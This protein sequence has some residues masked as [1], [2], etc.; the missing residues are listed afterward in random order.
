MENINTKGEISIFGSGVVLSDENIVTNCHVIK[1]A[2]QLKVRSEGKKYPATLRYSDQVRDICSLSVKGLHIQ[3]AI[4]GS[5]KMLKIGEKVY[6]IGAPS[7]LELTLS[8]GI[9]SSLRDVKGGHY[10]QTTAAI[11]AGS[12]G[13]GMFDENAM[14][15]GLTTFYIEGQNLNFAVPI[16]WVKELA[17]RSIN[18]E[19][20]AMAERRADLELAEKKRLQEKF[21]E[22]LKLESKR[23]TEKADTQSKLKTQAEHKAE[24]EQKAWGEQ[25]ALAKQKAKDER[26]AEAERKAEMEKRAEAERKV[27]MEQKAHAEQEISY[28]EFNARYATKEPERMS[29]EE[30]NTMQQQPKRMSLEEF[31]ALRDERARENIL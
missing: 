16:E 10:I 23:Q 29:I 11:S 1:D 26:R 31:N 18:T 4:I 19:Q 30:F 22:A 20:Q 7:G 15:V 17:K 6:A 21:Q 13:G 3:A 12:S 8:D 28:D 5:S 27:K 14:L 24:A 9:V 25:S 2:Y